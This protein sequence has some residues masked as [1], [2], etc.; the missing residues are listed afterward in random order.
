MKNKS[1]ESRSTET[2]LDN[3]KLSVNTKTIK[4]NSYKEFIGEKPKYRNFL[5][6]FVV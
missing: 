1:T 2:F 6:I 5:R 3:L 4:K